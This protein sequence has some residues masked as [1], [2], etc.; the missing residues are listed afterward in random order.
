M[1]LH[2]KEFGE[3][4]LHPRKWSG[5]AWAVVVMVLVSAVATTVVGVKL[6]QIADRQTVVYNTK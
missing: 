3:R 2:W 1:N 6:V 5:M 4:A